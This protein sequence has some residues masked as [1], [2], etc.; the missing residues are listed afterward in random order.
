MESREFPM[1]CSLK[2]IVLLVATARLA[3]TVTVSAASL[4]L[5]L[6][7][8]LANVRVRGLSKV[9][10]LQRSDCGIIPPLGPLF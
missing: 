6:P 7:T 4:L 10:I 5:P 1:Q 2:L 3:A 8:V 9:Q